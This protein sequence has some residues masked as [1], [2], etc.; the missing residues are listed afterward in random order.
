MGAA[1]ILF[2]NSGKVKKYLAISRQQSAISFG[3]W[4]VES[5]FTGLE[6]YRHCLIDSYLL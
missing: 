1:V 4:L 2:N 5:G 6:S 3:I